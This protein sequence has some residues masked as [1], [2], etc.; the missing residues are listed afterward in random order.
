MSELIQNIVNSEIDEYLKEHPQ[1]TEADAE[2]IFRLILNKELPFAESRSVFTREMRKR[3]IFEQKQTRN[4]NRAVQDRVREW[5]TENYMKSE[6]EFRQWLRENHLGALS[7]AGFVY[8]FQT[9]RM[10]AASL[11]AELDMSM[12]NTEE[13]KK[14]K[15]H[16]VE[17]DP[18]SV[19]D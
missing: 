17:W 10:I 9:I 3:G 2:E 4:D 12:H 13:D 14:E 1:P 18:E 7:E 5:L 19:W 16:P 11:G 6:T 15:P 8:Q